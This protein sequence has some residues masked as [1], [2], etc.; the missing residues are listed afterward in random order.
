MTRTR[1]L[2]FFLLA[3]AAASYSYLSPVSAGRVLVFTGGDILT[4]DP[5]RP[6]VEALLVVDGRIKDLGS[7]PKMLETG[8]SDAET[9]NLKG[10]TLMPGFIEPHTHPIASAMLGTAIDVSGFRYNSRAEVMAALRD[11]ASGFQPT[12]WTVAFGWDPMLVNDLTPPTLEELDQISPDRPLLILSQMMH[13][14]YA[15]TGAL[16]AAKIEADTPNPAGAEFV[17]NSQGEPTGHLREVGAVDAIVAAIPAPDPGAVRLL[18]HAGYGAYARAG[19]TT[20]APMGSVGRVERPLDLFEELAANPLVPVRVV[21][22]AAPERLSA[23]S[24]PSQQD[25]GRYSL[26]GVKFWM[27]GSPFTGGAAFAEPYEVNELTT[28]R[29]HLSPGY[30]APLIEGE[31]SFETEFEDF[32]QRGFQI[33][34]HVQGERAVDRVLEVA[35]RV[36]RKHPRADHRHRLEH[37]AL[38]TGDQL[39][40][41]VQLGMTTSFFVDHIYYYAPR[42]VQLVGPERARRYMPVGTAI[43]VGQRATLHSDS[44]ATPIDAMRV[45][46]TAVGRQ[47]RNSGDEPV[48]V[49]EAITIEQG[50]RAMTIDAAWQLGIEKETGSLQTGKAADFVVLSAN[51]LKTQT[52][53]LNTIRVLGTWIDGRPVDSRTVTRT[54]VVLALKA[55]AES[56]G[57]TA[58]RP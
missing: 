54:N 11:G 38:I 36:L 5:L 21:A 42:I 50:L 22:Y 37:N 40:R 57:V 31:A 28:K 20:I 16:K 14:A 49:E 48:A 19:F 15:N 18:V 26:R 10:A 52:A 3:A 7:L 56:L 55:L 53:D 4:M 58:A 44:P 35:E 51:P 45:L 43:G 39:I 1:F 13:D 12:P 47:P 46:K 33:A 34:V 8:G 29:L 17:R 30:L 27:D 2:L 32:H 24:V 9:V 41:A 23:S 6:S 25:H